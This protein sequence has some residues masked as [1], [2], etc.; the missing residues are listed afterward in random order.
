MPGSL[1]WYFLP[2]FTF[3]HHHHN[4][5]VMQ[6]TSIASVNP[7]HRFLSLK[8]PFSQ[9]KKQLLFAA[10][11]LLFAGFAAPAAGQ[12]TI[13]TSSPG[14]AV[15]TNP[16]TV[17]F[18]TAQTGLSASNFSVTGSATGAYVSSV[19]GSGTSWTVEVTVPTS[20]QSAG[21]VTLNM[22]NITGLSPGV[23]GLPVSGPTIGVI[24]YPLTATFQMMSSNA[25]PG[26]AKTGDKITFVL[27]ST[28]YLISYWEVYVAGQGQEGFDNVNN[29]LAGPPVMLGSGTAQGPIAWSWSYTNQYNENSS[30]SGTSSIIFDN[31]APTASISAPSVSTVNSAGGASVSYTVTYTD[32]NL[33]NTNLTTS[34]ITLN[35]TGTATGTVGVSGSGASYMVT[36]SN[37]TGTGTLGISVGAGYAVDLAGNTEATGA[38]PS[39]TVSAQPVTPPSIAYTG[40]QAYLINTAIT[41]LSPGAVTTTTSFFAN[42]TSMQGVAVDNAG[43]AYNIASNGNII[44]YPVNGGTPVI[45]YSGT[46]VAGSLAVAGSTV[47]FAVN[48]QLEA[49]D[50]IGGVFQTP[51]VIGSTSASIISTAATH[52]ASGPELAVIFKGTSNSQIYFTTRT[53]GVW[54]TPA[55]IANALEG[56][57][58][59]LNTY[60]GGLKMAYIGQ[61]N[62]LY[63]ATYSGGAWSTVASWSTPAFSPPP[64]IDFALD[65]QGNVWY[66][67]GT[68]ISEIAPGATSG[69]TKLTLT[70]ST[71]GIGFSASGDLYV[72]C[73]PQI[74]EIKTAGNFQVNPAL[75]AGLSI[76]STTGVISGM[77]TALSIATNYTVT[78]T[79]GS[80]NL[81][82]MVN[83]AT[84]TTPAL[85][86]GSAV[87][88]TVGTTITP[89]TP[90]STS[91][92]PQTYN[93]IPTTFASVTAPTGLATDGPGNVYIAE[94]G[95]SV[96]KVPAGGGIP[97]PL[98]SGN[99][100]GPLA[101]DGPGNIYISVATNGNIANINGFTIIPITPTPL[102][103]TITGS[104]ESA[105]GGVAGMGVDAAGNVYTAGLSPNI[106]YEYI[107][108]L[109]TIPNLYGQSVA[110]PIG[111]GFTLLS[112]LA[113]D[114][115]GD[116]YVTDAGAGT[117][118]V[119]PANRG[120]WTTLVSGLG[121]PAN[122][123]IDGGGNLYFSDNNT[124]TIREIPAGS[125]TPVVIASGLG[126][127]TALAIDGTG[128]LYAADNTNSIIDEFSPAGGYYI[129]PQLPP[130]FSFN[131][132]TA[133][134]SGTP[135]VASAATNYTITAYNPIGSVSATQSIAATASLPTLSYSGP[136]GFT[137][138]SAN[139]ITPVSTGVAAQG[140]A[141]VPGFM[142]SKFG[143]PWAVA[144]DT[145]LH[146]YVADP[147]NFGLK[148]L[149][150]QVNGPFY[151]PV[152]TQGNLGPLY[153]TPTSYH[154]LSGVAVDSTG[155]VYISKS[156]VGFSELVR[157]AYNY[158]ETVL[159]AGFV[160]QSA[161]DSKGNIFA[162]QN[163]SVVQFTSGSTTTIASGFSL[164]GGITVDGLGN[165]FVA[166]YTANTLYKIPAGSSTPAAV[167]TGFNQPYELAAD[168]TG[169]IFIGDGGNGVIKEYPA[170]GGAV[171]TVISGLQTPKGVA[172][173]VNGVLYV[174]DAGFQQVRKYTPSGGYYISPALPAGLSFNNSTGVISGTPTTI[175]PVK[176]YKITAYNASGSTQTTLRFGVAA[177]SSNLAGLTT[178]TGTLSPA[179]AAAT[180][181][182]SVSVPYNASQIT[183]TPISADGNA[184]IEVNGTAVATG[185]TSGAIALSVGAN[186]ITI[187]VT[188]SDHSS[189]QTY[190]VTVTRAAA[191][192]NALL[193]GAGIGYVVNGG[194]VEAVITPTT[195]DPM[196]TVTV[197]GNTVASGSASNP[198]PLSP[199][200]NTVIITVTAQNGVTKLTYKI[201]VEGPLSGISTLSSLTISAGTL[202]TAFSGSTTSYT[203]NV[204]NT[205]TTI[206]LTPTTTDPN[207]TVTVN[208]MAVSSGTASGGIAV[209]LGN[210]VIPTVVTAQDGVTTTTYTV[211]VIK[212]AASND[213]LSALKLST[214]TLSPVFGAAT[215]GYTA[216]VAN[217]INSITVTPTISDANATVKVNG[218]TV[219]SGAASSAINLTIGANTIATVVTAQDG[220]TTKTYTVTVT[221]AASTDALLTSVKLTPT[222]TLTVVT[223][224]AYV[225]YTTSVPN[226]TSSVS[227]TATEQDPTATITVNGVITA[228]GTASAPIALNAGSNTI[229]IVSTAQD[230]KT[231]KTYII[232][233]TRAA[234]AIA[235]L[236]ALTIS[237]GTLM[238]AFATATTVYTA[239]VPNATSS[240]MVT[241]TTTDPTATVTVNGTALTSGTASASILLA[242]GTNTITTTVT[243]QDGVTVKTYTTTVTRTASTDALLTSIKLTPASTLIV[244]TGPSYVNY[245]T[246]V[247]NTSNSITVTATEQ[248]PTAT[249]TVNGVAAT[250]G[251]PSAPIALTVGTNVITIVS[252]AQDGKTTKTYTITATKPASPIATLSAL[253]LSSG[254]LTPVF[255]TTTISY[256]A[257]VTNATTSITVTPTT[258]DP[259]ATAKVNGTVVTSGT[260]SAAIPLTVGANTITA[261]VTAQDGITT[262]TYTV[263]VT[264]APSTDALLT[265]VKL[266]PASTLTVVT[267]PSYVNYTTSVPNTTGSVTV[268]ATEQDLTATIKV[269]GTATASSTASTPIALAVGSNTISIVSTAQDGVTTKT[270]TITATRAA[271]A[272]KNNLDEISVTKPA[273]QV[274]I[275]ND[276]IL[277]HQALSPNGDGIN[278]YFTIDN[279]TNYPDNRLMIVDRNGVMVYQAKGYD[280]SSKLFD[281]HSNI[282][283]KMQLPGTYFYSLDYSV[284][285]QNKHKTGYIILKY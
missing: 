187:V 155:N 61:D 188:A 244:V 65:G 119:I 235:T 223:G 257:S 40:P 124:N 215:T 173:D 23:S 279:I 183:L 142:D 114:A 210:T 197:D 238:P 132:A 4:S 3:L 158:V 33:G 271:A 15:L 115:A 118:D 207:A 93:S 130:G 92:L 51:V 94:N 121:A 82:A 12:V 259:A 136:L 247:A 172:V 182:Y 11:F 283:G 108:P 129:N 156:Q 196:A 38:G 7:A 242:A 5:P 245:T 17:T 6:A 186:T 224:P 78:A 62:N 249:L 154:Q 208:G 214:G 212:T 95:G 261:I 80:S 270:Y 102:A 135:I 43:N 2:L 20:F 81:T 218:T 255:A 86:Y 56:F 204:T 50:Y 205:I 201:T 180:T 96:V 194:T 222:S 190:T 254:T 134:I 160:N 162:T 14:G 74:D 25:N 138:G 66:G 88:A 277:V 260:A 252:T 45:A 10:A 163:T 131:S 126:S 230:G 153:Y 36:I 22:V 169:N 13:T 73:K 176:D 70:S 258:T 227:V 91:I 248:D 263:T 29:T 37:I 112:G 39:A 71:F 144:V 179:F 35:T 232:T 237:S 184:T 251:T 151:N 28:Y 64:P 240:I 195:A 149:A 100:F 157:T 264:R 193:S 243:A 84:I 189:T 274:T 101:T 269:N 59:A 199:G 87:N 103:T 57:A 46:A 200:A 98:T 246:T 27:Q 54:S 284:N 53:G 209:A 265:S 267:G 146:V 168:G 159:P 76:N 111:T 241:P 256:T 69:S 236:S 133:V 170:G 266:T 109:N 127:I 161:I 192:S 262:K 217:S 72:N 123:C 30:G 97:M 68:A 52:P 104:M 63:Y 145:A 233:A 167:A 16:Y 58:M 110:I 122:I 166:D 165:I 239:T 120:Q 106:V 21:T 141:T 147:W 116:V 55:A 47:I 220:V 9:L 117:I 181:G 113:V 253:K 178:S 107:D 79:A 139:V 99:T 105:S 202:S 31:I 234:S 143:Q 175:T 32:A 226:A 1:Q 185:S 276:G 24:N 34:G 171:T 206:T 49:M 164:P 177:P 221:R 278:D 174:A 42:T 203:D 282:N 83:I 213:N 281:G 18:T 41:P 75:P 198:I 148:N 77:P 229:N 125:T 85:S 60:Q 216:S 90:T 272:G 219:A 191:S 231:T 8:A 67:A 140:Y 285:G 89:I 150:Y 268:T 128:K 137:T 275:E 225:N 48:S 280:N 273:E 26:Y 152:F 44:M 211:T 250:S 19:S 228:S